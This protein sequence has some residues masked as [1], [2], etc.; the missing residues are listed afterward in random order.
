MNDLILVDE[1]WIGL[2]CSSLEAIAGFNQRSI[3]Q[4]NPSLLIQSDVHL[5][6]TQQPS[7]DGSYQKD[8]QPRLVCMDHHHIPVRRKT[9][10]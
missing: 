5:Y 3:N 1:H 6:A 7:S 8:S 2:Q 10:R 9:R 4:Y